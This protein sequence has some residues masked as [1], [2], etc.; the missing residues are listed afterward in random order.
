MGWV[1]G[2]DQGFETRACSDNSGSA[3]Y[4]GLAHTALASVKHHP[5]CANLASFTWLDFH[6]HYFIV[7]SS[8]HPETMFMDFILRSKAT[9]NLTV[10]KAAEILRSAQNE[11]GEFPDG[12]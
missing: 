1:Q 2:H 5:H 8:V 12:N 11:I 9:K 10:S 3:G 7:D 6:V 4:T